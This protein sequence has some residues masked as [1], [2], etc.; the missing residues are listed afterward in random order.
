M[1]P[2]V[3][4]PENPNDSGASE[5]SIRLPTIKATQRPREKA[6][7]LHLMFFF[8]LQIIY[9]ALQP[10]AF[11]KFLHLYF[12]ISQDYDNTNVNSSNGGEK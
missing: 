7:M 3:I 12:V 10:S 9:K 8:S 11:Y 6:R 5:G 4:T 2:Q 1:I